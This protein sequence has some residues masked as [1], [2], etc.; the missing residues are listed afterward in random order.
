MKRKL[1]VIAFVLFMFLV[2]G[3]GNNVNIEPNN[4]KVNVI[5]NTT[6]G[7]LKYYVPDDYTYRPDLRGLANSEQEKKVHMK[8]DYDN[9]PS[10]V[11]V[12]IVNAANVNMGSSQYVGNIN[13]KLS[14]EDIKYTIKPNG[15]IIEIYAREDYVINNK[16]NYAYI[17]DYAGYLHVVNIQGP[18]DK[19]EEITK[20]AK[21][22]YASLEFNK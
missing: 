22:V 19:K 4:E 6:V 18:E 10:N 7:Y 16:V 5:G 14:D 15:K 12:L 11:I 17:M 2:V 13:E 21:E 20:L 3:C 1:L 8:G 9:D